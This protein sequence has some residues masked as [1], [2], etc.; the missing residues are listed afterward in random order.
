MGS[1]ATKKGIGNMGTNCADVSARLLG[2]VDGDLSDVEKAL[3]EKHL[4]GCEHCRRKLAEISS[5][6]QFLRSELPPVADAISP[7]E[8][9]ALRI[10]HKLSHSNDRWWHGS[11]SR[12][13]WAAAAVLAILLAAGLIYGRAVRSRRR[14]AATTA[15]VTA[16][17]SNPRIIV[18]VSPDIMRRIRPRGLIPEPARYPQGLSPNRLEGEEP[19]EDRGRLVRP[20]PEVRSPVLMVKPVQFNRDM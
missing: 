8:F 5:A 3:V 1:K 15:E 13:A 16:P 10:K 7:P 17:N 11:G 20:A 2:F 12:K 19:L 4:A 18:I 9:L 6:D 14:P